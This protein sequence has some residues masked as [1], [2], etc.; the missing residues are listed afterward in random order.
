MERMICSAASSAGLMLGLA[1]YSYACKAADC[2]FFLSS[3]LL[4]SSVLA[5]FN[6]G[7]LMRSKA[8]IT[9]LS[10]YIG[11]TNA[12]L[13]I[14][15]VFIYT[16]IMYTN[17][18]FFCLMFLT[19]QVTITVLGLH[20]PAHDAFLP[21]VVAAMFCIP[22]FMLEA[23]EGNGFFSMNIPWAMLWHL[24]NIRWTMPF[25]MLLYLRILAVQL[26]ER[27]ESGKSSG[28]FGSLILFSMGFLLALCD[29]PTF[30]TELA[31]IGSVAVPFAMSHMLLIGLGIVLALSSKTSISTLYPYICGWFV[32]LGLLYCLDVLPSLWQMTVVEKNLTGPCLLLL[33]MLAP[34]AVYVAAAYGPKMSFRAC[35]ESMLGELFLAT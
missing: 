27:T 26:G 7:Y 2:S 12:I 20:I 33:I 13:D 23:A 29:I 3:V 6:L 5:L 22:M 10:A 4:L 17:S 11:L 9:V 32:L 30:Q 25:L 19:S 8:E 14:G 35:R 28:L 31:R 15:L 34:F 1:V 24:M 16:Q 18:M 21:L